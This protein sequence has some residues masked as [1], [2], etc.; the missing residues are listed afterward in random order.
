MWDEDAKVYRLF[1]RTDYQRFLRA[2]MEVRGHR[3]MTNPD[4]KRNP[5][6]W[7]LGRHWYFNREPK[8]YRRRQV[9][10]MSDWMYHGVHF[11]LISGFDYPQDHSEGPRD[12]QKRHERDVLNLSLIHI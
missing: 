4:L 3:G 12:L 11:A 7:K 2:E 6:D 8:E 5:T 9:Y 10:S 1:T